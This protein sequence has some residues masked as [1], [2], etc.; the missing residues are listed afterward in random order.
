MVQEA[1]LPPKFAQFS[2]YPSLFQM[3]S[4]I[5]SNSYI[6]LQSFDEGQTSAGGRVWEQG[7]RRKS[8]RAKGTRGKLN[9]KFSSFSERAKPRGPSTR[10]S[11]GWQR[12][13]RSTWRRGNLWNGIKQGLS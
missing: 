7:A 10:S 12:S 2:A 5:L 6:H 4:L 11:V 1:E 3:F 13:N 8:L 9:K